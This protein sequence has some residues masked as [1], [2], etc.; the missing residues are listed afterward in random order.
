MSAVS[1]MAETIIIIPFI[2]PEIISGMKLKG[3]GSDTV[4]FIKL[5]P[6]MMKNL[7]YQYQKNEWPYPTSVFLA[8]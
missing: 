1:A 6:Q 3:F 7:I 4:V 5:V 2:E 8:Y